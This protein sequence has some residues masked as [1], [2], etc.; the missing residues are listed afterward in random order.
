MNSDNYEF[1]KS[2]APQDVSDYS[3][4][5]DKQF[6]YVNDINSGVYNT[7]GLSL[8]QF[9]LSSVYS[10][11]FTDVSDLFLVIPLV[12]VATTSA[13]SALTT[14]PT[15]GYSL[16]SLKSNYQN[17]I[18]QIEIV[19]NGK[20]VDDMQPFVNIFKNF[21]LLSEM[22]AT[23]LLAIAPTLGL[24]TSLD[25]EKSVRFTTANLQNSGSSA[26]GVASTAAPYQGVGLC[27]NLP[28]AASG[29]AASGIS[30]AQ[31]ANNNNKAIYD[32]VSK[33]VD[34]TTNS[35]YQNIYGAN[36]AGTAT[37]APQVTLMTS[38]NLTSEFKP[39]YTVSNNVMQWFDYGIIPL[40]YLCDCIDKMGLVKKMDIVMRFYVNTGSIQLNVQN[41]NTTNLAYGTF[42][43]TFATTCP[44]TVNWLGATSA[45]G[46]I[47]ATTTLIT[48][49]LFVAKAPATMGSTAITI[50]S[51]ANT[52]TAC[53]CYYSQVQLDPERAEK[54]LISNTNKQIVYENYLFNQYTAIGVG[55]NFSQLVQS[56]IK[57]P[58]GICIIPVISASNS[59]NATLV[60]GAAVAG[61]FVNTPIAFSQYQSPYDTFGASYSPLSLT[62]FQVTLGGVNVLNTSLFY[63]FENFL[64]Q[65]SMA[66][67][68]TSGDIGISTGLIS[69]SWWE[70][71]R[72]YWVD[73]GRGTEAEKATTRNLNISFQN[74]N[75]VTIDILVFTCYLDRF[76]LNVETGQIKR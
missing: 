9:D 60:S 12:M 37:V 55:G 72:V 53:R 4:Y 32:R 74:N 2:S 71:N 30:I 39:H 26:S 43:S 46:G 57:N 33:I 63:S 17:L 76:I 20:T 13:G 67:T 59:F 3:A 69:Q 8:V 41:P 56:G 52:M 29:V 40:K 18:H 42:T 5:T 24:S 35:T 34:T 36:I 70:M 38:S 64:E 6:N 62:N 66:E 54:Y 73:L 75:N 22:S 61:T 47:A 25:N 14:A 45:N 44:L 58:I 48:A 51:P 16:C 65:V 23:D 7:S 50:N 27:N 28:F 21:K 19:A 31:N 11:G 68:L 1:S 10:S 15:A 49:G